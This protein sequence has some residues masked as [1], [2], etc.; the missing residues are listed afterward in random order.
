MEYVTAHPDC[1][2]QFHYGLCEQRNNQV[3]DNDDDDDDDDDAV[4]DSDSDSTYCWVLAQWYKNG[5]WWKESCGIAAPNPPRPTSV[6]GQTRFK[7]VM[8]NGESE[9]EP[10]QKI[11]EFVVNRTFT[12]W[13]N[14]MITKRRQKQADDEKDYVFSGLN[15][16][17]DCDCDGDDGSNKY[18][19]LC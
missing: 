17:C 3:D 7:V 1:L 8:Q 16:D 13:E 19:N 10:E 15:G 18:C 14:A 5:Q 12:G 11:E 4:S 2:V 9:E 6:E